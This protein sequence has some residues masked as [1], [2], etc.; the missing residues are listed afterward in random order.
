M[1]GC[2]K[3]LRENTFTAASRTIVTVQPTPPALKLTI[4]ALNA[5]DISAQVFRQLPNM[6]YI[7]PGR[8]LSH[9]NTSAFRTVLAHHGS[10]WPSRCQN[11]PVSS[12]LMLI[13]TFH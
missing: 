3:D 13:S 5:R 6:R 11:L 9:R 12:M 4:E 10:S 1:P 2:G 8:R 7:S